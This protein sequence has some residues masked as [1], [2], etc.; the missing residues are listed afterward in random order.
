MLIRQKAKFQLVVGHKTASFTSK[1]KPLTEALIDILHLKAKWYFLI[2]NLKGACPFFI[3]TLKGPSWDIHAQA[4]V[5]GSPQAKCSTVS[6]WPR[7]Y[8]HRPLAL[9]PLSEDTGSLIC[10]HADE[11]QTD[12]DGNWIKNKCQWVALYALLEMWKTQAYF[13]TVRV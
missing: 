13:D 3:S 4:D 10:W 9:P 12:L 7:S 1:V 11:S 5:S 2:C 6:C 8:F